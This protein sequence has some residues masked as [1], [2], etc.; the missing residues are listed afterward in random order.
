MG[1][2][3]ALLARGHDHA[4]HIAART[5]LVRNKARLVSDGIDPRD[6]RP[7]GSLASRAGNPSSA[8]RDVR[9]HA[10]NIRTLFRDNSPRT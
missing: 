7:V 3:T 8:F 6:L 4:R 9:H 1:I 2:V 5:A 10:P